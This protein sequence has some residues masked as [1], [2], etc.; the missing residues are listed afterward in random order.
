MK[1]E[2]AGGSEIVFRIRMSNE[3]K[4]YAKMTVTYT[5][6]VVLGYLIFYALTLL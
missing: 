5:V 2:H 4:E 3:T 1:R 6:T